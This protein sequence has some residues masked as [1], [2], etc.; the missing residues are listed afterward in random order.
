MKRLFFA[1]KAA[2]HPS[3]RKLH[4]GLLQ[5][6]SGI[7]PVRPENLHLTLKFIGDPI[8]PIRDIIEAP[9]SILKNSEIFHLDIRTSGAFPNWKRPSVLWLGS[10]EPGKARKLATDLD[11]ALNK[12]CSIPRE[13]REFKPHLTMAR[14]REPMKVDIPS[15]RGQMEGCLEG[16]MEEGYRIVFDRF[17]LI[18][19]TLT[20]EGPEYEVLEEYSL[21]PQ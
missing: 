18:N 8:C 16:L 1:V 3:M 12:V 19:S 14:I 5:M 2:K 21:G 20:P 15:L 7:K 4:E 13:R 9:R 10:K 11:T 6:G 17:F